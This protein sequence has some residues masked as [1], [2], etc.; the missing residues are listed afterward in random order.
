MITQWNDQLKSILLKQDG[1]K[2]GQ[3][4]FT[5]YANAFPAS[6]VDDH[7]AEEATQDIHVLEKISAENP[8]EIFLYYQTNPS[9]RGLTAGSIKTTDEP[10]QDLHLRLFQW[11]KSIPL[12]DI[13]PMLENL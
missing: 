2:K 12:S 5:K 9:S 6:Y 11:Q 4:I 10:K 3:A 1:D 8:L 13:L 7:T